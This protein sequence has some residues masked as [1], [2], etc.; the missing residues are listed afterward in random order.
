MKKSTYVFL[1]FMITLIGSGE[2]LAVCSCKQPAYKNEIDFLIRYSDCLE[3][4][5]TYQIEQISRKMD[6]YG[7]RVQVLESEITVLQLKIK[8]FENERTAL[9]EVK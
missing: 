6:D 9:K 1:I 4:C 5:F 7:Q 8:N 3:Q 2:A